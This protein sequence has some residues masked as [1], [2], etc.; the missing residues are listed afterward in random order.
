MK[1]LNKSLHH[2]S[3]ITSAMVIFS[4]LAFVPQSAAA[5]SFSQL[6]LVTDDQTVNHAK[7]PDGA[8]KNVWGISYGP[9]SPFWVSDNGT[10][11]STLY[12][13]NPL[14]NATSKLGLTV[15]IPGNGS[16]TGQVF[17]GNSAAFKGDRFIFV[18][19]DGTVSGWKGALGTKAETLVAGSSANIYKGVAEATISGN[20]YI[21]AA[22]FKS[23]AID[24][25]NGASGAPSLSGNFKDST[26]PVGYAPFNI[27][28]LGDKLYVT[29]ALQTPDSG[30]EKD[31]AHLGFVDVFS[32]QGDLLSRIASGD[33]LNAPWGLAI[34]PNSFGQF[35]GD[36]LVGNFGD[37]TINAFNLTTHHFDG[38]LTGT[39]GTPLSIDGLWALTV[40]NGGGAGS[41]QS[42]YFSAGP[43]GEANGLFGTVAAVPVPAAV[44]LFGSALAGFGVFGRRQKAA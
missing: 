42:I 6:N 13:V 15:S 21:Y 16:V 41:T 25:I 23:G 29:Y 10:G 17:N 33:T 5:T 31:G 22:N 11:V 20:S 40:G 4:A 2:G 32:T 14:T 19:E 39:D 36:L 26:L 30:D 34:A 9:T 27:Q 43:N 1:T 3:V 38:Q 12:N 18:S 7:I 24:V 35:A 8:L 37:G 28:N 44:W